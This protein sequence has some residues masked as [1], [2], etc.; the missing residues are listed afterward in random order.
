MKEDD[1]P[2]SLQR[3]VLSAIKDRLINGEIRIQYYVDDLLS[4][5]KRR[6]ALLPNPTF[7]SLSDILSFTDHVYLDAVCK[8]LST[9]ESCIVA[10]SFLRNR[11]ST[12]QL[13]A[14]QAY[15]RVNR[16][17]DQETTGMYQVFSIHT[18]KN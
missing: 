14:F 2:P 4:F 1:L 16:H 7:Y 9:Q 17:D 12:E 6:A 13:L 3:N 18:C 15:G 11:L 5:I 10:R 8:E